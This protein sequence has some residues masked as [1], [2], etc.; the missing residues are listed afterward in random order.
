MCLIYLH[1]LCE[2]IPI[3][4]C[5]YRS[6]CR[7]V[8]RKSAVYH[9]TS[10]TRHVPPNKVMNPLTRADKK[11][12]WTL[13]SLLDQGTS[14]WVLFCS[15][16]TFDRLPL[17]RSAELVSRDFTVPPVLLSAASAIVCF[18]GE[19]KRVRDRRTQGPRTLPLTF[20]NRPLCQ[21]GTVAPVNTLVF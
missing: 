10:L 4:A 6:T 15:T 3:C 18:C 14:L 17:C 13:W 1:T 12:V 16:S 11:T 7:F 8:S 5:L 20:T 2:P 9:H 19:L 21:D